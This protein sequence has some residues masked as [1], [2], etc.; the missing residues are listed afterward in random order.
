MQTLVMTW[1]LRCA[2]IRG[3]DRSSSNAESKLRT[4]ANKTRGPLCSSYR[5]YEYACTWLPLISVSFAGLGTWD[6]V[7]MLMR[8]DCW[9]TLG[10]VRSGSKDID[11][12][13]EESA[14]VLGIE[15]WPDILVD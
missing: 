15:A 14:S 8:A 6:A 1:W 7:S 12:A 11:D 2:G 9:R 3:E 5:I 13:F 10:K 4:L